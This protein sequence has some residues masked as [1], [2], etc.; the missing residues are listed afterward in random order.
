MQ[1]SGNTLLELFLP[2]GELDLAKLG[3][4]GELQ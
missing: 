2:Q 1:S 4:L 3:S